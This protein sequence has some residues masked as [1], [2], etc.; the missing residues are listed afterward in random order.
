MESWHYL[1]TDDTDDWESA[2]QLQLDLL[3][4]FEQNMVEFVF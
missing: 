3:L 2:L 1:A 4:R